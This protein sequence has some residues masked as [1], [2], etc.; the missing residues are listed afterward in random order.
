MSG[1]GFVEQQSVLMLRNSIVIASTRKDTSVRTNM[2]PTP[3][4]SIQ[5]N[6]EEY[7]YFFLT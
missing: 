6:G 2:K 1:I 7:G 5:V 4:G 3:I